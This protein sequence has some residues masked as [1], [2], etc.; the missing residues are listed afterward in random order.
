MRNWLRDYPLSAMVAALLLMFAVV[1][2][3]GHL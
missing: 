1:G 3:T 2:M